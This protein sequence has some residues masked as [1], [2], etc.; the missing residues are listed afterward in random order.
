ME[1]EAVEK[2]MDPDAILKAW[3]NY[4]ESVAKSKPRIYSTLVNNRPVVKADGT[5]MVLLYSEAQKDNFVKNIKS[6]L[7]RSIKSTTGYSTIE[8]LTEVAEVEK[9]GKRIYTE[10]DKL[11]SLMKKNPELGQLKNRFSLDFDD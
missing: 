8:I 3:T 11:D 9:N 10:Q 6:D 4:A 7:I 2:P 5:I 1:P